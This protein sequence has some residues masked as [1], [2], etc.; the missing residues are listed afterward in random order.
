M[1][2]TQRQRQEGLDVR[3]GGARL[4]EHT[5]S[6]AQS[7]LRQEVRRRNVYQDRHLRVVPAVRYQRGRV[8][9]RQPRTSAAPVFAMG[10]LYGAT[11]FFVS[12]TFTSPRVR[13]TSRRLRRV[14]RL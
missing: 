3:Y 10:K 13:R 9:T 11:P 5:A 8:S 4:G 14:R 2:S 1:R 7:V 6:A 12:R